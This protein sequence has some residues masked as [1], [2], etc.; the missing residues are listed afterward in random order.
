MVLAKSI[1]LLILIAHCRSAAIE[2][3]KNYCR[4][5]KC[6]KCIPVVIAGST[7]GSC[8]RC[9][10]SIPQQV[11][12]LP[13]VFGCVAS[14]TGI[15]NCLSLFTP[16]TA[17][18]SGCYYCAKGYHLVAGTAINGVTPYSCQLGAVTRC[19][20]YNRIETGDAHLAKCLFCDTG[21]YITMGGDPTV[22]TCETTGSGDPIDNCLHQ[23]W[24]YNPL[25]NDYGCGI[26]EE[27][28]STGAR[29][30]FPQYCVGGGAARGCINE[31][32]SA[33]INTCLE[34]A[35]MIG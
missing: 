8:E 3:S 6:G 30:D 21:L 16:G 9:V 5:T 10:N 2:T 22:F 20:F 1:L 18:K 11:P 27:K 31:R 24:D 19:A 14:S 26:C 13:G 4:Q 23:G 15:A 12:G 32:N 17:G 7:Y 35:W 28:Y 33:D 34:C 25:V 29:D